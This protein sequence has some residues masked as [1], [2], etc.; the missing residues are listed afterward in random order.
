MRKASEHRRQRTRQQGRFV[1]ASGDEPGCLPDA[2][3]GLEQREQ[4]ALLARA[5]AQ[6]SDERRAVFVLYEVEELSMHDVA[7]VLGCPRFT[8]YTR[9]HAARRQLRGFFERV[10]AKGRFECA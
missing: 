2:Q 6:L 9:L 10:Q 1:A 8:A 7:Q 3:A 4:A 5:L